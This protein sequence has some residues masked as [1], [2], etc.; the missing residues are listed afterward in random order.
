VVRAEDIESKRDVAIKI[1]KSKKP[2]LLQAKTEIEL[3]THLWEKDPGDEHNV[4][5][6][7]RRI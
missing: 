3:L 4:G 7:Y 2:F 1:I 6:D 5:K